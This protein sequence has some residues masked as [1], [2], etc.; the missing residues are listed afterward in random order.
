MTARGSTLRT[1][2]ALLVGAAV[3][4]ALAFVL[5]RPEKNSG[6]GEPDATGSARKRPGCG[7]AHHS[8]GLGRRRIFGFG[9]ISPEPGGETIDAVH[10]W[11]A[12][13]QETDGSWS[14]R[15]HEGAFPEDGKPTVTGLALLAFLDAGHTE[16]DGKYKNV[17]R[18]GVNWLITQQAAS[19]RIG[20]QDDHEIGWAVGGAYNH[21]VAG[22]ALA[23]AYGMSRNSRTGT[24]AQRAVEYSIDI[25]DRKSG[26]WSSRPEAAPDLATTIWFIMQLNSAK[27]AGLDVPDNASA[28]AERFLDSVTTSGGLAAHRPGG[29]PTPMTAAL[30][31]VGRVLLGTPMD[32]RNVTAPAELLAKNIPQWGTDVGAE[33]GSQFYYWYLGTVGMFLVG[34][35]RWPAWEKSLYDMLVMNQRRGGDAD[36]SWDPVGNR[37]GRRGGRVYATA[38]GRLCYGVMI[39]AREGK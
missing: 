5:L 38:L 2:L 39:R 12:N 8:D 1:L 20:E 7:G 29:T 36:G 27:I 19:G 25:Q 24:A 33:G 23:E 6:E 16:N 11:L 18:A 28:K 9:G 4:A 3:V 32:D 35:E 10:R 22:L 30:G 26:G 34:G 13:H 31:L 15:K 21:A 17:V 37:D 14:I